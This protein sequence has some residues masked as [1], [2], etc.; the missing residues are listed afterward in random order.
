[1]TTAVFPDASVVVREGAVD[2]SLVANSRLSVA[3]NLLRI[4]QEE[5][6]T[7]FLTDPSDSKTPHASTIS[8]QV[9]YCPE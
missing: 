6:Q 7:D 8:V 4:L 9:P 5:E 1:M 2:R 3:R